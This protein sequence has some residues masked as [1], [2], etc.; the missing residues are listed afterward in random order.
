[1]TLDPGET[2]DLRAL[3]PQQFEQLMDDYRDYEKEFGVIPQVQGFD[4]MQQT[5]WNSAKKLLRNNWRGLS[6][7]AVALLLTLWLL[8]WLIIR[9]ISQRR[10]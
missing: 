2:N 5:R 3:Q 9:V 7:A 10:Q 1:L 8:V 6:L 4:Y